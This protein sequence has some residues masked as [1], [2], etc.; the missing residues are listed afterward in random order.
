MFL[1]LSFLLISCEGYVKPKDYLD[2]ENDD[3][4]GNY[5]IV[6][7]DEGSGALEQVQ[8]LADEYD[9]P[10]E[11]VL[12]VYDE[13]ATAFTLRIPHLL[14]DSLIESPMII[15]IIEDTQ[16]D[17]FN[18]IEY[19][20]E[21]YD[22][23]DNE[24]PHGIT[25]INGPYSGNLPLEEIHVAVIDSGVDY[26]HS[27]LNVVAEVDLWGYSNGDYGNFSFQPPKSPQEIFD[28]AGAWD[29]EGNFDESK[30]V[31]DDNGHGTHVAGT[32]GAIADG[33]GVAGVAPNVAI[34]SIRMLGA[35]GSGYFSDVLMAVEYVLI[36]NENEE[37]P[38]IRVVNMSLGGPKDASMNVIRDALQKLEDTGVVVC[39]AAGNE[40]Q[41]TDNVAPAGF[42][43]G[44]VVSA[45]ET[46]PTDNGPVDVG[47][48]WFSNYG[49][50]VDIAAPGTSIYSTWPGGDYEYLDG[51][52]MATPHV[53]GAVAAFLAYAPEDI[54]VAEVK[55]LIVSTGE[56]GYLGQGGDH[57]EPLLDFGALM[58]IAY[59]YQTQ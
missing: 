59:E 39:I 52:S 53:A 21:A 56:Q 46:T 25:R 5:L 42:D 41:D 51:T 16:Q 27:D 35:D 18:P 54:T 38:P 57:P 22:Y 30:A 12:N 6:L 48:A 14:T 50:A 28:I 23:G 33:A 36:W 1:S 3:V 37:H 2:K 55:D 9:F 45:Y 15:D 47:F 7:S 43:L 44:I 31:G 8:F 26:A 34:H 29:E 13:A 10:V 4:Y 11:N 24:I 32:I 19:E 58:E 40:D 17:Y 20:G 49:T